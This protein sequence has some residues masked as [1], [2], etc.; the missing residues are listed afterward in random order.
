MGMAAETPKSSRRTEA[1]SLLFII[2]DNQWGIAQS[3][4][5]PEIA[6]IIEKN[7]NLKKQL[8]EILAALTPM[9][10]KTMKKRQATSRRERYVQGR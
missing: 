7:A 1:T 9:K 5:N 8:K 3:L 10:L 2:A 4:S 6:H